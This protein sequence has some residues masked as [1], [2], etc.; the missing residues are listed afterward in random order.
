MLGGIVFSW[1]KTV[2]EC[3]CRVHYL[4]Y[5]Q[6]WC[7]NIFLGSARPLYAHKYTRKKNEKMQR[8][9]SNFI[10]TRYCY[11]YCCTKIIAK[12][13]IATS[14]IFITHRVM[15]YP[16]IFSF[17]CIESKALY[18]QTL[19]C[20]FW[21]LYCSCLHSTLQLFFRISSLFGSSITIKHKH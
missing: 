10:I 11:R 6:L 20:C 4:P 1:P 3:H 19:Y 17:P 5:Y 7:Y 15:L 2:I 21:W 12:V 16:R 13:V 8:R 9:H 18:C 14:A